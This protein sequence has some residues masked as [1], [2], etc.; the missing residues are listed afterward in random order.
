MVTVIYVFP[1]AGIIAQLICLADASRGEVRLSHFAVCVA[2]HCIGHC[3]LRVDRNGTLVERQRGDRPVDE[4]TWK[5]WVWAFKASREEVVASLS[6]VSYF[7]IVVRD[8]PT[9]DLNRLAI[10]LNAWSTS[11]FLAACA[12]SSSRMFRVRQLVAR[13]P[14]YVPASEG[15][16]R[17]LQDGCV[18][19]PLADFPGDLRRQQRIRRLAHQTQGPL[20]AGF[21][22]K[23]ETRRLF[24][25]Y[26]QSLSQRPVEHRVPGG[27]DEAG[28]HNR[29]LVGECWRPLR[30]KPAILTS[31]ICFSVTS[32]R[33][34]QV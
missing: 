19:G 25:L 7:S 20:N 18:G 32:L 5:A 22:H 29:V 30:S 4:C 8:S 28:Q 3:E 6:G 9:R 13:S 16:D 31:E 17:G 27:V 33:R 26:R 34:L 14:Q 2:N 24:E 15:R 23:A 21:G 1:V 11:S 10:W 12:S